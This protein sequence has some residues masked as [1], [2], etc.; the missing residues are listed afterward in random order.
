MKYLFDF[1]LKHYAFFLFLILESLSFALIVNNNNY[2]NSSFINSANQIS[3]RLN[4]SVSNFTSYLNLKKVNERL[5]SENSRLLNQLKASQYITDTATFVYHDTLYRY[6]PAKIISASVNKSN[7][8]FLLDKG[9]L[10]GIRKDLGVVSPAGVI[11]TVVNVTDHYSAVMSVLHQKNRLNGMIKK[12]GHLGVVEWDGLNYRVGSLIDI[13]KHVKLAVGDTVV[14][15][16]NSSI[17][18]EGVMIGTIKKVHDIKSEKFNKADLL[19]SVDYN[20]IRYAYVIMN[21]MK[22]ET[23]SLQNQIENE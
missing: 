10:H 11:G 5:I 19:F 23:D 20:S 14:T 12:N 3:G 6:I 8:Y 4:Y 13:P 16:S 1:I 2:Q 22:H 18:P 9:R 7:N 21:L 17:Y 15:S